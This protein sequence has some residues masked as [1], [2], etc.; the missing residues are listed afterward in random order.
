MSCRPLG[1]CIEP[2]TTPVLTCGNEEGLW[3]STLQADYC[4]WFEEELAI[5]KGFE[6]FRTIAV[7]A[8][9]SAPSAEQRERARQQSLRFRER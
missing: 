5:V 2:A 1:M 8:A 7:L 9:P 3:I 4:A 6:T